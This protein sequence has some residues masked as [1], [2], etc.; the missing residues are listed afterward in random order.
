[1]RGMNRVGRWTAVVVALVVSMSG[2]AAFGAE[3]YAVIVTGAAGGETYAQKYQ[4]LRASFV[5]T[6]RETFGYPADHL[7]VLAEDESEDALKATREN[8]Q[9]AFA[10]LRKRLTKDD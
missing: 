8:V 7:F 10:D 5:K 9:R 4:A 2:R 6:L 3:R 1:M